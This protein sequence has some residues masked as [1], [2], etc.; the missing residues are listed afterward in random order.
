MSGFQEA[1]CRR[2]GWFA[3]SQLCVALLD[4]VRVQDMRAQMAMTLKL[5]TNARHVQTMWRSH[6]A[7]SEV[8]LLRQHASARKIQ[9]LGKGFLARKELEDEQQRKSNAIVLI[10]V[11]A[12]G[13]GGGGCAGW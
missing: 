4:V 12:A 1:D 2:P 9:A 6:N 13:A 11:M 10:Q 5:N 7:L 8:R 3:C